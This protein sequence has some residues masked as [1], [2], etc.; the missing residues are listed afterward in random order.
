MF[1]RLLIY[2]MIQEIFIVLI[3]LLQQPFSLFQYINLS[4]YI[5]FFTF[6]IGL[7]VYI[8]RSGFL[9]RVHDGFRKVS[10]KFKGEEDNEFSDMPLSELVGIPYLDIIFSSLIILASSLVALLIYYM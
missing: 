4:F 5:G 2:C 6:I 8:M 10:R 3:M 9:D 1:K 7:L